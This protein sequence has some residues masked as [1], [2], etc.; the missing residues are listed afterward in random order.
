MQKFMEEYMAYNDKYKTYLEQMP[1][2]IETCLKSGNRHVFGYTSDLDVILKWDTKIFNRILSQ[3]LKEEPLAQEGEKIGSMQDFARIVSYYAIKGLGGEVDISNIDVCK[4]LES[5][6]ETTFALGGTC[7]QGAAAMNAVGFPVVAHITDKSREVCNIINSS[8][9]YLIG[10]NGPVAINEL[11]T[12]DI[13]V[14]HMILQY[15]KGDIIVANGIE[16]VVPESN[17]VIIDYDTIHKYV[18]IERNFLNYCEKNAEKLYS[19]NISGFNAIIDPDIMMEKLDMLIKHYNIIKSKNPNCILYFE[20][21]HYINSKCKMMIF[22]KLTE[23]IDILGMNEEELVDLTGQLGYKT[24]KE[25]LKSVVEGLEIL[26]EKYRMNGIV[27]HTKD[28]SMYYGNEFSGVNIE[29]GLTLGN[30]MSGTRART[31]RYGSYKDCLESLSLDLS[32]IGIN[33]ACQLSKMSIK[34]SA[35]LIPSRYMEHPNCTIGLGDTFTAGMQI[36]F[37]R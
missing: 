37:T 36:C 11:S 18:P 28:Y 12:R 9:F 13:P 30:I 22:D 17:R 5:N 8:N 3:Y 35:H 33:F 6:F 21:A 2:D 10:D 24:N 25:D 31:G 1:L 7:A 20:S 16:Y 19:Y 32:P 14:R 23:H 15:S 34:K 26:T 27:M 29:K 4:Y